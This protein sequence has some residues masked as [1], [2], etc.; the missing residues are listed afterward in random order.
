MDAYVRSANMPCPYARLPV[1][2]VHLDLDIGR[3]EARQAL[4][5]SLKAFYP[6]TA[7]SI[8]CIVPAVQP[9][10]HTGARSWAYKFRQQLVLLNLEFTDALPD[11]LD[12]W[13]RNL[14]QQYESWAR[15]AASFLGPRIIVESMDLMMTAFNPCYHRDHPRYA[16]YSCIVT[17]RT[18]DLRNIHD[19][20]PKYSREI[21][22]HSKAKVIFSQLRDP[23][24]I[25][26]DPLRA[27]YARWLE[28]L[29]YYRE[30]VT[31]QYTAGY[32]ID[33]HTMPRLHETRRLCAEAMATD[34]FASSLAAFRAIACAD[35]NV[36]M[37]KRILEQNP[38]LSVFDIAKVIFGDVSGMYVPAE[39]D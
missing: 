18:N 7:K 4:G 6:D 15:D 25:Q 31:N 14:S 30:F 39:V 3:H 9:S 1:S 26:I 32:R 12:E 24:G 2:Y 35:S 11:H 29:N 16:P 13:A 34:R 5:R 27:E 23:S 22:V 38:H 36:P 37:L 17:I 10:D 20:H 28:I 33:P 8:L 19:R 21:A